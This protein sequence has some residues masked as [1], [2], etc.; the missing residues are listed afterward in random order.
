MEYLGIDFGLKKIGLAVGDSDN[1]LAEPLCVLR[2]ETEEKMLLKITKTVKEL[3]ISKIVVGVSEGRMA[4]SSMEFGNKLSA[5]LQVSVEFQD[6]AFSTLDAQRL[7][8]E[9]GLKRKK[10]KGMEDAYSATLILQSWIDTSQ[11]P[12]KTDSP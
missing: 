5:L 10:R 6:E 3:K 4:E 2:A 1:C 8:I 11:L 12:R 7:S 9:A